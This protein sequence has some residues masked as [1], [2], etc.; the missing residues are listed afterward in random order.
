MTSV[1]SAGGVRHNLPHLHR[2]QV[3]GRARDLPHLRQGVLLP[4]QLR[5][6]PGPHLRGERRG[7]R[8]P[9]RRR[10]GRRGRHRDVDGGRGGRGYQAVPD[11]RSPHR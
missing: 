10:R 5:L 9:G 11:V 8:P 6:A 3:P 4:L 2:Q 1:V 7:A